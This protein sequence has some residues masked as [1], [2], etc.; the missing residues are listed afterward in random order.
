MSHGTATFAFGGED[1][2]IYIS[3]ELKLQCLYLTKYFTYF[4]KE[5]GRNGAQGHPCPGAPFAASMLRIADYE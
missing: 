4:L 3:F 1:F 5:N 2:G